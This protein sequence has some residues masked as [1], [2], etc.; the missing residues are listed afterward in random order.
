MLAAVRGMNE[1]DESQFSSRTSTW[2]LLKR[3]AP[4]TRR[5]LFLF[6]FLPFSRNMEITSP[7]DS[8]SFTG[9][10]RLLFILIFQNIFQLMSY[11][12]RV[13]SVFFSNGFFDMSVKRERRLYCKQKKKEPH[14]IVTAHRFLTYLFT[15]HSSRK[16]GKCCSNLIRTT[17]FSS[18]W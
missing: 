7:V 15:S 11:M 14:A 2:W 5:L 16:M 17:F 13:L 4:V 12:L 10:E 8:F 3:S 9:W 18:F 6:F 1:K